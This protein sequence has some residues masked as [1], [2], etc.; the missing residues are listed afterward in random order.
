MFG[1]LQALAKSAV[2]ATTAS[3][4]GPNG[5]YSDDKEWQQDKGAA[6]GDELEGDGLAID[7]WH[8]YF[9]LCL[10]DFGYE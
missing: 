7:T 9:S 8:V 5:K 2:Q 6:P 3:K 4:G 10:Q 1:L